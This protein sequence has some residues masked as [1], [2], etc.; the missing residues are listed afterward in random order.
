VSASIQLSGP[1][2]SSLLFAFASAS[3]S[4]SVPV[5]SMDCW[6]AKVPADKFVPGATIPFSLSPPPVF[7]G[8]RC[9]SADGT[10]AVATRVTG[11]NGALTPSS[12]CR[13]MEMTI[14]A[15]GS[16]CEFAGTFSGTYTP[17]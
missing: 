2:P 3:V 14:S 17:N 5:G 13:S 4:P 7:C 16:A 8:I 9:P 1:D 6:V 15:V 12:D 10:T 11:G